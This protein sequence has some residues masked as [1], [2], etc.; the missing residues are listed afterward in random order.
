MWVNMRKQKIIK[1]DNKEIT[2]KE[3]TVKDILAMADALEKG[4]LKAIVNTDLHRL[5]D[6]KI[7][8]LKEMAP[9][10]IRL[11]FEAAKE[12]NADFLSAARKV[13]LEKIVQETVASIAQNCCALVS[14][15]LRQ[16]TPDA[17][18]TDGAPSK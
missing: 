11:V 5:T 8:D 7:D 12:V 10:E 3:L 16:A 18:T 9:S 6:L 1:I 13:G 4:D 17:S 14:G 15:S 2:V